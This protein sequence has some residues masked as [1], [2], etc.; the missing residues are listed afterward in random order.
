MKANLIRVSI[1]ALGAVAAYAQNAIKADIPFD[2]DVAGT[3]MPA[4]HYVVSTPSAW[5]IQLRET[6]GSHRAALV[7]TNN[8]STL[9]ANGSMQLV[10]RGHGDQYFLAKVW[11]GGRDGR[12]VPPSKQERALASNGREL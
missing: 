1:L 11:T 10:F 12:E 3:V 5:T 9:T 4:G 6:G 2:F 8:I 7:M